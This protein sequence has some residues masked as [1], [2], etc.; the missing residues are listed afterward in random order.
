MEE[1]GAGLDSDERVTI[2]VI[3]AKDKEPY[4]KSDAQP[5]G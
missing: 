5:I 2:W 1:A 4:P 3:C